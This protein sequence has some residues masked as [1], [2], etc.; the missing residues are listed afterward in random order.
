MDRGHVLMTLCDNT[1]QRRQK[2]RKQ[3]RTQ[4]PQSN[5]CK[6]DS[7]FQLSTQNNQLNEDSNQHHQQICPS[8]QQ[9][10]VSNTKVSQKKPLESS[11]IAHP[12]HNTILGASFHPAFDSVIPIP[13]SSACPNTPRARYLPQRLLPS[14]RTIQTM[15][16]YNKQSAQPSTAQ[17]IDTDTGR[18]LDSVAASTALVH[19]RPID[20]DDVDMPQAPLRPD[21]VNHSDVMAH[22]RINSIHAA[23]ESHMLPRSLVHNI[24]LH[25]EEH[26]SLDNVRED[27]LANVQRLYDVTIES[28]RSPGSAFKRMRSCA[29]SDAGSSSCKDMD[30]PEVLA[31]DSVPALIAQLS[32]L[33]NY[34]A[35]KPT[36]Q[37]GSASFM[38]DYLR[39][40]LIQNSIAAEEAIQTAN[41]LH[42][43]DG[44]SSRRKSNECFR[45]IPDEL[46]KHILSF[47]D[48]RH[49]AKAREVCRR[50][51][52]FA[53]DEQLWKILCLRRWRSL[54]ID[55]DIWKLID[56]SV[57]PN[58]PT[59]WRQIYPKVSKTP[60]WKCRLQKTGRFICNLVAHQLSGTALGDVGLPNILVVERRFNILHLQTFVLPEAS[61]LYYEP[62]HESDRAGFEEFI[63][64]LHKRTRAGLALEDQRR[65]I[66]IPP[67]DYTRNHVEYQG[68][69]LLGVVQNAYPPLAP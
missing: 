47:L 24:D 21:S 29:D 1:D 4:R 62:E 39:T 28:P 51:N 14:K 58:A 63:E 66:F 61:V 35:S 10:L 43:A 19:S 59:R 42:K 13:S 65:F 41:K 44:S 40:M 23:A 31:P 36:L 46:A 49:L 20:S 45:K 17:D 68:R 33:L 38:R 64:Y 57:D 56:R 9:A 67:C 54:D 18:G 69:S 25:H 50:W 11:A 34:V 5:P 8:Q 3:E 55:K 32:Q 22:L 7:Q 52:E 37:N 48:G 30:E 27:E 53:S 16:D 12:P 15:L 2:K 6:E 26:H 60:Q